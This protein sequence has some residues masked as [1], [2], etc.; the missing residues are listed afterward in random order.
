MLKSAAKINRLS[1]MF[2]LLA[3]LPESSKPWSRVWS[4]ICLLARDPKRS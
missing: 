4:G 3:L 2:R 1:L